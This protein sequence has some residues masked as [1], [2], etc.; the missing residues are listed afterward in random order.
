M[1]HEEYD[2]LQKYGK[3]RG[4]KSMDNMIIFS[5]ILPLL[6]VKTKYRG[7]NKEVELTYCGKTRRE[8][9]N[10]KRHKLSQEEREELI[11]WQT[12]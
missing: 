8:W 4:F 12:N 6:G 7:T 3:K 9:G 11:K 2:E 10:V 1:T 5:N